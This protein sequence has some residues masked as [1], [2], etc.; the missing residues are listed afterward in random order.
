MRACGVLLPVSS[1]PSKYGIGAFSKEAYDFVDRLCQA[2]Q[3]YW[4]ILPLGPTGYG[5]SPYQSFSTFA[6]NPYFIDLEQLIAD[7][8]LTREQCEACDFGWDPSCI[9]YGKL[10]RE[11]YPLLRLAFSHDTQSQA[12]L[13]DFRQTHQGWLEDYALYM[14]VKE[15]FDGRC[16]SDWPENIR[17]RRPEAMELYRV[18]LADTVDFY[19]WLQYQ[20][21]R[22]WRR[23]KDYANERGILI[24]G[25]LPIYV[26][27]D[28]ADTWASPELFQFDDNNEPLAVAG[29]PPDGFAADGQLWGN[30]LYRW[31]YHRDTDYAWWVRRIRH[32]LQL[33]DVVRIDH[34]RGF[35][36]YYSI[37]YGA[38]TARGGHWEPGPG[39]DFFDSVKKQISHLPVIAEDLGYLT[40]SV[41]EL[42][43]NTGF[44]GMKIIEFAFDSR[45]SGNYMPY[46]YEKNCVVYT[47]TH[48]NQTLK[49]WLEE[50]DGADRALAF[51]YL[52]L[53]Q[54]PE[55][56]Y[57]YFIRLALSSVADTAM[58]P[59]QDYLGLGPEARLNTPSTLGNN[60][61]W[62]LEPG[63]FTQNLAIE[64][65]GLAKVYG[66]L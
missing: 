11:R 28:S 55:D 59:M 16:W 10:Y 9:D 41:M 18:Q 22:Q 58:I 1:L 54:A 64:M 32:S 3:R 65:R 21:D 47:G 13:T 63:Q 25:D 17:N 27:F 23:L 44:P 38:V 4:Q 51:D 60:W 46:T 7:G 50:M 33:Y 56:L 14:A 43:K 26:A 57:K 48:D 36:E 40:P 45:E 5:D 31:D 30:P 12:A 6:G 24:I 49:G 15:D 19:V 61:C 8:L 42:V 53:K 34:F 39:M 35:D 2:G 29:C 37:P 20:F 66:R 52:N 62:R